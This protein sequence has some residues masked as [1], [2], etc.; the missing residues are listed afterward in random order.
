LIP[1]LLVLSLAE[2]SLS[3]AAYSAFRDRDDDKKLLLIIGSCF[4]SVFLV[5]FAQAFMTLGN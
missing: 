1:E 3:I 4:S 2:A 5:I